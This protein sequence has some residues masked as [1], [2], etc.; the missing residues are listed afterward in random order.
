MTR[1]PLLIVRPEPGAAMTASRAAGAG[2]RTILSPIFAIEPVAWEAP[3]PVSYDALIVTSANAVRQAGTAIEHYAS[4][5]AYAVGG[6][7]AAALD[8]AGF[9]TVR[10]G[11]GDAAALLALAARD[12]IGRALHLA[13]A[14]HR[15]AAHPAIRLDRRIVYRS[16]ALTALTGA[17][18]AALQKGDAIVLLHSGRAARHFRDLCDR[19]GIHRGE[20]AIA[21]LAPA[22]Q[23]DSGTGWKAVMC[24]ETPDDSALLAAAARL[25]H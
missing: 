12:G 23:A 9:E 5:P 24:A 25:C 16:A 19:S 22:I 21:A 2:W 13:G 8:A 18:A 6:A 3:D 14:D 10:P 7:T 17:A 11:K 20:V 4:L 15:A 1:P